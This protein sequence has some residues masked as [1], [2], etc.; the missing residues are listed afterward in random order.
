[1][2]NTSIHT[3]THTNTHTQH[4]HTQVRITYNEYTTQIHTINTQH[5]STHTTQT[6]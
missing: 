5:K 6:M 4:I 2:N 3:R 1:M